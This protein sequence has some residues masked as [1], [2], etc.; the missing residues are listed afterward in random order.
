ME[1][2]EDR[3]KNGELPKID[4]LIFGSCNE[5]GNRINLD[6]NIMDFKKGLVLSSFSLSE[7]GR[8][9]VLRA[10]M[11]AA[12]KIFDRIPF[13]G[14]I[15]KV[16]ENSVI[17]NLGLIDE[18]SANSKLVSYKYDPKISSIS[19]RVIFT[20]K[21]SDTFI[22]EAEPQNVSDL[23]SLDVSDVIQPAE[24]MRARMLK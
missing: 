14:R 22:C 17:I 12:N 20:V 4:F 8:N 23:D 21:E 16:K 10:A 13:T 2:I 11:R 7:N 6:V 1:N 9:S 3:I 15:L 5:M 24:I 18:I 19:R